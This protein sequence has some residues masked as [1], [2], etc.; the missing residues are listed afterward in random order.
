MFASIPSSARGLLMLVLLSGQAHIARSAEWTWPAREQRAEGAHS[1]RVNAQVVGVVT[2]VDRTGPAYGFYLQ[3]AGSPYS[4]YHVN[5]GGW[6]H[7]G[8]QYSNSGAAVSV[9]DSVQVAGVFDNAAFGREFRGFSETEWIDDVAITHLGTSSAIP[10]PVTRTTAQL[11]YVGALSRD[12]ARPYESMLVRV[13]G[14][15]RVARLNPFRTDWTQAL[16]VSDTAPSD[17]ILVEGSSLCRYGVDHLNAVVDAVQGVLLGVI[18]YD[19][20]GNYS[21]TY[22]LLLRSHEDMVDRSDPLPPRPVDAFALSPDSVRI[23]FNR[24]MDA[25]TCD[26][27]S[28]YALNSYRP[29]VSV[30]MIDSF[31]VVIVLEGEAT[32]CETDGVTMSGA[33]SARGALMQPASLAFTQLPM[34][35]DCIRS[36]LTNEGCASSSPYAV[37]DASQGGLRVTLD[38]VVAASVGSYAWVCDPDGPSKSGLFVQNAPQPLAPGRRIRLVGNVREVGFNT[39]F[40]SVAQVTETGF[41][42]V[43]SA[44]TVGMQILGPPTCS[45]PP[46]SLIAEDLE[47]RMVEL[48]YVRCATNA[49]PGSNFV[50]RAIGDTVGSGLFVMNPFEASDFSAPIGETIFLRGMVGQIDDSTYAVLPL[51]VG[52]LRSHGHN[53][54]ADPEIGQGNFGFR[55]NVLG[56]GSSRPRLELVSGS[57]PDRASIEVFDLLGRLVAGQRDLEPGGSGRQLS[58]SDIGWVR[59][60]P[61]TYWCRASMGR[62]REVRRLLIIR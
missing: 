13:D 47:N 17:S 59:P 41:D 55:L 34:R 44:R 35:V 3:T 5:T 7:C 30:A 46:E 20:D 52:D 22:E 53:V 56:N 43:P 1:A 9:G 18:E 49:L 12:F 51:H 31:S 16:L 40:A 32:E 23:A 29:V 39:I 8:S 42:A 26:D 28:M 15:L 38:C 45:A 50:I 25:S 33:V 14:P 54:G 19:R 58:L 62:K 10:S 2:A 24:P 6:S 4:G 36:R 57:G 60:T 48:D 37:P 11:N 27:P 21:P 61:G